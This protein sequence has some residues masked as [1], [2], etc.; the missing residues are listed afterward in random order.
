MDNEISINIEVDNQ[1]KC[2]CDITPWDGRSIIDIP[3]VIYYDP[4]KSPPIEDDFSYKFL[5]F[6]NHS[7]S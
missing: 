6:A 7:Q 1:G 3:G 2:K 5:L 4:K